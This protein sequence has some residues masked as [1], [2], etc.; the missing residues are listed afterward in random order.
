MHILLISINKHNK[1]RGEDENESEERNNDN[2]DDDDD[3]D[4]S[5]SLENKNNFIRTF[6]HCTT[7]PTLLYHQQYIARFI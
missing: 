6:V 2:D 7:L 5:E 4:V 1:M 3:D